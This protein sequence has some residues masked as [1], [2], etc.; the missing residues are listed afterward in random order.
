MVRQALQ[1]TLLTLAVL[2]LIPACTVGDKAQR[3][4]EKSVL[5]IQIPA[6]P[7]SLDPAMAEDGLSLLMLSNMMDGLMGY[8]NDGK[9]QPFL[10]Q[11]YELSPDRKRYE[12][13]IRDAKWSD[14]RPVYPED[15]QAAFRRSLKPDQP[16]KLAELFMLIRGAKAYRLGQS[17]DL[18]G[19][20]VRDR[21]LVIELERPAPYFLHLLTLPPAA[22]TRVD[23]LADNDGRWPETA[24]S[25]GAYHFG[26]YQPDRRVLLDRNPYYW[27]G[28]PPIPLVDFLIVGDETTALNLFEQGGVD[29]LTRVPNAELDRLKKEGVIHSSPFYATYYIAF[30]EKKPPFDNVQWRRAVAGSIRRDE[31]TQAIEMT[32]TPALSWIPKGL[33]GYL[34]YR[35]PAPIFADSVKAVKGKPMPAVAAAFDSG[36]RNALIM[37]KIQH[38]LEAGLGLKITLSNLDWKSYIKAMQESPAQIYRF[39]WLAPIADPITHLEA[40]T[41]GNPNNYSG[42]SNPQYDRLVDEIISLEPGPERTQK[43]VEAEKI[44]VERDAAVVPIYHYIQMEAVAG[45]VGGFKINPFGVIPLGELS[46]TDVSSK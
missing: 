40:W 38:D 20:Y 23:V 11:S 6:E 44:L 17:K 41:T 1:V 12:F 15:F 39:G 9:L 28:V 13:T 29:I 34:P 45:R 19:V 21:K 2:L 36:E 22:P 24:P 3:Q 43:I 4:R 33:E 16:S 30:N 37:Q 25:T 32:G 46:L 8:D 14:G 18:P 7:V 26:A 31:I 42:W 27:K 35:D 10:A 5:R